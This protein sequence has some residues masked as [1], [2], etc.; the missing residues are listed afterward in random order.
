MFTDTLLWKSQLITTFII[1]LSFHWYIML[2]ILIYFRNCTS[3]EW[4]VRYTLQCKI[5]PSF[6]G[7]KLSA[8]RYI[9][10][11]HVHYHVNY[12]WDEKN[13]FICTVY[14]MLYNLKLFGT[15]NIKICLHFYQR[16]LDFS[17][18]SVLLENGWKVWGIR[19]E[20]CVSQMT[21]VTSDFSEIYLQNI[22]STS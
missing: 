5:L 22:W 15:L 3:F 20:H 2:L 9:R 17:V 18:K 21:Q 13:I 16:V 8:W 7:P 11:A 10:I 6:S 19:T 12:I 14:W 4:A 1:A